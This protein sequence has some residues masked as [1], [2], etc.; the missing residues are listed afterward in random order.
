L[1]AAWCCDDFVSEEF[2]LFSLSFA[3]LLFHKLKTVDEVQLF[4]G[5]GTIFADRLQYI[6]EGKGLHVSITLHA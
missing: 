6:I 4:A 5:E 1:H 2:Q 3:I